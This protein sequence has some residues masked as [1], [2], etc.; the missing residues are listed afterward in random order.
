VQDW[1]DKVRAALG[2]LLPPQRINPD[3]AG[4]VLSTLAR[5]PALARA[6][7]EFNT[8]VLAHSTLSPRVREIAVL[9]TVARRNCP[10]LWSHHIPIAQRAGLSVEEITRIEHGHPSDNADDAVVR[11][12]DDIEDHCA[13][14]DDTWN[15]LRRH[16][17]DRQRMDLVFTAGCYALLATAINTFGIQ[18][19]NPTGTEDLH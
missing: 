16:L 4:N 7:L 9:R 3:D 13:I 15:V 10:Y 11:A 12:I 17:D 14:S 5:H 1:D 19:E 6:Y 8:H 18:D 2:V